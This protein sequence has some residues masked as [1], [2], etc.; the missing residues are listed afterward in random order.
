[1]TSTLTDQ[2][3]H[4]LSAAIHAREVSC[5]EVMQ[6]TLARIEAVN[7]VHNAIVNL[8][9]AEQLL[10]EAD[11]MD[12]RLARGASLGWLHGIPQAIKDIA[13]V[14]GLRTTM[15]SP[16][17]RDFR[18]THDGLM[19]QRMKA[20]GCIVIG[21]TNTPEFG[22]GSHT[23][24]EVFGVTGNAY[25]ASKSA[26]GSSG[27]AAVALATRMLCVADGSDFMGSLRNPA[28][29]NNVF[30]L[31]PSQG[32]VPYWPAPDVWVSQ[33]GTEGPMARTAMDL[34]LLLEVQAGFDARVPLS[35][36]G[37]GPFADQLAGFDPAK[38]SIGWLGDLGGHLAMEPGILDACE[39]G[40]KRLQGLGC[41]VEPIAL[42]IAPEPVWQT[43][44]V[45]RRWLVAARIA[46]LLVRPENRAHIK[47]E[48][49]WEHD[50]AAGL[51]GTQTL[52]ASTQRSTF[53]Q[54]LLGL[55][56]DHDFLA[57]P[58]AQVW[59][60]DASERWPR[61]INGREMDTYHR[62]MEVTIYATLAG[63]PCISVPVGFNAA[64]LPMGLQLIGRPQQ[65][66]SLL[67]LAQAYEQVVQD[68]LQVRPREAAPEPRGGTLPPA[69]R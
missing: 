57:L 43:W 5:R 39:S 2:P 66:L 54:H 31:R 13:P 41:R 7:P 4:A 9:D 40:L 53:Y 15:G 27:G 23:F 59:P 60:F 19:V 16:L 63:L 32:R 25:D 12:A 1:M 69:R 68:V 64:G 11:A 45:W 56:A 51:S 26:G 55:F 33:L 8:R 42:G 38:A 36:A 3:A 47:P 62:W 10:G 58:T 22:L 30:G 21:R 35:I 67:Q 20:A 6:A 37:R 44:L 14:A 49:L 50:Q 34:A 52:A 28:G 29:W 17:L 61:H 48:A 65:D 18:P 24:N 46:P